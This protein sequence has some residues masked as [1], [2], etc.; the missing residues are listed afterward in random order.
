MSRNREVHYLANP[1]GE[2]YFSLIS[3]WRSG[4]GDQVRQDYLDAMAAAG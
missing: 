2:I 1:H 4:G 3:D